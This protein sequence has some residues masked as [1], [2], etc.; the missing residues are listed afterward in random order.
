[1]DD[2]DLRYLPAGQDAI[3]VFHPPRPKAWAAG[4]LKAMGWKLEFAGLPMQRS[5]GESGAQAW[6]SRG[7]IIAYPHTSNWDGFVGLLAIWGLGLKLTLW[8]KASLFK[9][10]ILGSILRS[11]GA[12][13]VLRTDKQGAVAA[14]VA[15]MQNSDFY[16]LGLAPEGT[17]K[18]LPGWRT[19]F[20]HVAVEA[21]VPVGIAYLDWGRKRIGLT[22]FLMLTG[23]VPQD[24][25][26][27][28]AAYEG[29]N[30]CVPHLAAPICPLD[31]TFD[32]KQA[33]VEAS[34]FDR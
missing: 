7:V 16:W 14:S 5:P 30:G 3:Q 32:R 13:P 4:L 19:G 26:R 11:A 12:I 27:L 22:R 33:V 31:A 28:R 34:K 10:P 2:F 15:A 1:M 21:N 23:D 17:R 6:V 25:A 18:L 24:F 29:I 9:V 20:Y 8:S